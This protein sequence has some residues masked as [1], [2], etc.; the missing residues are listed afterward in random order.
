MHPKPSQ[1][2]RTKGRILLSFWHRALRPHRPPALPRALGAL[3]TLLGGATEERCR[4]A[5]T[6][7]PIC[8]AR[9]TRWGQREGGAEGWAGSLTLTIKAPN[10]HAPRAQNERSQPHG[11]HPEPLQQ[12]P[13]S[14]YRGDRAGQACNAE[15]RA[16]LR[17][18]CPHVGMNY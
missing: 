15:V 17:A 11:S 2:C 7:G 5:T 9:D 6:T 8:G 1:P 14:R 18:G 4:F 10:I 3:L 12:L 13:H 16:E